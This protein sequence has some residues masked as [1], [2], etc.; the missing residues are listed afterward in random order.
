MTGYGG[1]KE[2][3]VMT[4]EQKQKHLNQIAKINKIAKEK[5]Q[6]L[7]KSFIDSLN[8]EDCQMLSDAELFALATLTGALF[9]PSIVNAI[10]YDLVKN[11]HPNNGFNF[12]NLYSEADIEKEMINAL[13]E[14]NRQIRESIKNSKSGT[15]Q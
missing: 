5:S 12:E 8:D 14:Y 15:T 9:M 13:K 4:D 11:G 2:S 1:K 3:I 10:Y 6:M 7:Y